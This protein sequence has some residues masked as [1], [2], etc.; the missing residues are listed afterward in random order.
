ML[1][2]VCMTLCGLWHSH[3][4]KGC[5]TSEAAHLF[6][7]HRHT[8]CTTSQHPQFDNVINQIA[9]LRGLAYQHTAATP[10]IYKLLPAQ[11]KR[12]TELL[13]IVGDG[14]CLFYALLQSQQAMLPIVSEADELRQQLHTYFASSY[15]DLQWEQRVPRHM[16]DTISRERFAALYLK[17]KNTAHVPMDVA[18]IW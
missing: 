4:L 2:I 6:A 5:S 13:S 11:Y 14:R 8:A 1:M 18:A 7:R 15:T 17:K 9:H 3:S 12:H 16:R 10:L